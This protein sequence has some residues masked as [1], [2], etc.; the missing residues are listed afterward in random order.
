MISEYGIFKDAGP[1]IYFKGW[2]I[3]HMLREIISDDLK[4]QS[5]LRALNQKFYH[6]TIYSHQLEEFS[7]NFFNRDFSKYFDQ[8]LRFASVPVLEYSITDDGL[9]Y[10]LVADVKGLQIPIKLSYPDVWI[11]ATT[12]WTEIKLKSELVKP[13]VIAPGFLLDL[14]Q[15]R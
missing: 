8:Y 10:R 14:K 5:F 1:D 13:L 3:I 15:A 11:T 12:N 6:R 4:F 9:K 2:A 7:S